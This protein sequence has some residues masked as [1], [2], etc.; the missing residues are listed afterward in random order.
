MTM[1][2]M[3]AATGWAARRH[4]PRHARPFT[5][6]LRFKRWRRHRRLEAR[7]IDGSAVLALTVARPRSAPAAAFPV[8]GAELDRWHQ[9]ELAGRM[10][11]DHAAACGSAIGCGLCDIRLGEL[12]RALDAQA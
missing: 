5:P 8:P 2:T 7:L 6:P 9:I 12:R 4:P 11:T 10:L 3:P 1:L